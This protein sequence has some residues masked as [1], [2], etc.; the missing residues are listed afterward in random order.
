MRNIAKS[1]A[2]LGMNS[3]QAKGKTYA[4]IITADSG[5]KEVN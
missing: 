4:S 1:M 2:E 5:F 3:W